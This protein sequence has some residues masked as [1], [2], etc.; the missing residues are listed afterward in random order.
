MPIALRRLSLLTKYLLKATPWSSLVGAGVVAWI[1]AY[2]LTRRTCV[3][4]EGGIP[5]L[6]AAAAIRPLRLS[7]LLL[8]I[9][10]A[11]F[12][13]DPAR[14]TAEATP[15][16]P[17]VRNGL[18]ITLGI[19]IGSAFW[20]GSVA[21]V[22]RDAMPAA[23]RSGWLYVET[24]GL[25]ALGL[26]VSTLITR[27]LRGRDAGVFAAPFTVVFATAGTLLPAG[28]RLY[29]PDARAADWA[30]SRT[31]WSAIVVVA[32][33]IFWVTNHPRVRSRAGLWSAPVGD[34]RS[35]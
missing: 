16:P 35:E 32:L 30:A 1:A 28:F 15:T 5:C 21:I 26:T 20:A 34:L 2:L 25:V 8:A 27:A 11:F 6:D 9:A 7:A 19:V 4:G 29:P 24:L 31:Y 23:V 3:V 18:R 10:A 13:D 14:E 33:G 17:S 22:S 12:L